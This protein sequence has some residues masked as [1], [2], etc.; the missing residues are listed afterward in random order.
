VI[1]VT[2]AEISLFRGSAAL[3]DPSVADLPVRQPTGFELIVHLKAA[4][5]SA[6]RCHPRCST[7]SNEVIE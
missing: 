2:S 5:H 4:R 3:F 7:A 1:R 6:L